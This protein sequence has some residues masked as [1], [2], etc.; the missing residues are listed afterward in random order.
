[1]AGQARIIHELP[2]GDRGEGC[3]TGQSRDT[4]G[5]DPRRN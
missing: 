1:M 5:L 3:A 2:S 4:A